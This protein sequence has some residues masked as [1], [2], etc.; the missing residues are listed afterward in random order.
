[1]RLLI[2][3]FI[4]IALTGCGILHTKSFDLNTSDF[5]Q[6][7]NQDLCGAYGYRNHRVNEARKEL[8]SRKLFTP[9]EWRNIDQ[10][11]VLNGMS[12]CAVKAAFALDYKKIISS[13][14]KDGSI[15]KSLI[16]L[17]VDGRVPFCP[18]TQVDIKNGLVV[19]VYE[20]SK[21]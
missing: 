17:C 8:F 2:L 12:E 14:Y 20:R 21:L 10:R 5:S 13:S 3:I 6:A 1:M 11:I 16:Y 15:G 19:D 18:Y 4:V 9:T 7:S